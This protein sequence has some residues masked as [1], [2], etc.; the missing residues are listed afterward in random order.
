MCRLCGEGGGRQAEAYG[1]GRLAKDFGGDPNRAGDEPFKRRVNPVKRTALYITSQ[2]ANISINIYFYGCGKCLLST[3]IS[4]A[5]AI[6]G[7][8]YIACNTFVFGETVCLQ[9]GS[10]CGH[11]CAPRRQ[12]GRPR[13]SS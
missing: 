13:G 7:S 12:K 9:G 11:T 1:A 8:Y 2:R 3:M 5:R 10:R 4:G 6:R